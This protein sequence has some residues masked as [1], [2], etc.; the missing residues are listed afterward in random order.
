MRKEDR[1][2]FIRVA[3]YHLA[4]YKAPSEIGGHASPVLTSIKDIGAGGVCLRANERF[5]LLSVLQLKINFPSLKDPVFTLAKVAWVK[6]IKKNK[7]YEIGLQFV[8]IDELV[9]SL[10]D[11][12]LKFVHDKTQHHKK[13]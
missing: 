8:E 10:V 12:R 9:R 3:T 7:D 1:R 11:K 2:T 4:K 13:A 6:Q 5:P